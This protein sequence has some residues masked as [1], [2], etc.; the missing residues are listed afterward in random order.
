[1]EQLNPQEL[2]KIIEKRDEEIEL[3]KSELA[4]MRQKVDALVRRVFGTSSEK[5]TPGQLEL[6][7]PESELGKDCASWKEEASQIECHLAPSPAKPAPKRRAERWPLDLPVIEQVLVPE[8]VQAAPEQWRRIGEE[9]SEQLDYEPGRFLRRRLVRPKFVPRFELDG[10]P[11]IAPLPPM[12]QERCTAAPGLLAKI[13]VA[14]YCDHL[15]LYRQERIFKTRHQIE[16]PRQNM[17][18]WMALAADWCR[19][20]YGAIKAE[21]LA[22]NYVQVDETPIEYLDPGHGSTRQGYLWTANRPGIGAVYQWETSRATSCLN[23][24]IPMNFHGVVQ[25]DGY[26]A[27]PAFARERAGQ[28]E[29]IGCWAHVRRGFF[30]AQDQAPRVVGWNLRQIAHLYWLEE[31]LREGRAGPQGRARARAAH[32]RMIHNRLGK[33]LIRLKATGRFLPKSSMG[34]ALDYALG[35]WPRL[36]AYLEAGHL[37]ID[38]NLVENA[39]R[40]TAIG[41]KNWLFIGH[42]EAGQRGAIL[43]TLI[44]QCRRFGLDPQTY[45]R[46]LLTRLPT[47]TNW[48]V[49]DLTPHAWA[50][51][52]QPQRKLAA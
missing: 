23:R 39:I 49:K 48:Q 14:K 27:Y 9:V 11:M 35:Q 44:E 13:I 24:L 21:V 4:L 15:P 45:L 33:A 52:K 37:E 16:L 29:L 25:C 42:A 51:S 40:P 34:Q 8:P 19:P 6:F 18:R 7:G 43:Y 28:I 20:V 22:G 50:K 41:K 1:M 5:L 10:V 32:S 36:G 17:A 3:L 12:L 26:S 47:A 31:R 2:L 46:E 30:E 38:N